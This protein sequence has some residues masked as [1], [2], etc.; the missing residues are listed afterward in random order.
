MEDTRDR[1]IKDNTEELL[2]DN[3]EVVEEIF[4]NFEVDIN[5]DGPDN[6]A[7]PPPKSSEG[8]VKYRLE[9]WHRD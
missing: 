2:D 6:G 1:D 3:I 7:C 9:I 8:C 5:G 4:S